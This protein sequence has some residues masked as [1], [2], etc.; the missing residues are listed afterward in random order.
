VLRRWSLDEL[1]QLW[2]VLVGNMSLVGPRPEETWVV[3]QYDDRQRQRLAMKP[4]LTGPM[5]VGGRGTLDL[6]ARLALEMDYIN[7][8]SFARDLVILARTPGAV[9]SGRGA[10]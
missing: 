5:Q 6:E 2:N 9:H 10:L 3:A 4:G 7:N 8:Y 1:P